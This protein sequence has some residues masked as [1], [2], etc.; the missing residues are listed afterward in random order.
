LLHIRE[1]A[2][3]PGGRDITDL[4]ECLADH[5]E[6]LGVRFDAVYCQIEGPDSD[7]EYRIRINGEMYALTGTSVSRDIWIRVTVYDKQERAVGTTS[8]YVTE[9]DFYGFH[10]FSLDL[11]TRD[12]NPY[13]LRLYPATS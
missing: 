6:R 2:D 1:I 7:D 5:E 8:D 4:V 13:R 12:I 10:S 11:Y 3:L 9:E